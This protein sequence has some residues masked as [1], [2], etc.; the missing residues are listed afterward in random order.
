MRMFFVYKLYLNKTA[1]KKWK[2]RK[3]PWLQAKVL[4]FYPVDNGVIVDFWAEYQDA[5]IFKFLFFEVW[6]YILCN[7]IQYGLEWKGREG[8]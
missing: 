5:E 1:L 2:E 6:L 4:G 8:I 3:W 7:V